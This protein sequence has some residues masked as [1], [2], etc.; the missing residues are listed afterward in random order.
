MSRAWDVYVIKKQTRL[1]EASPNY[2]SY[3][4]QWIW[5][6]VNVVNAVMDHLGLS[7]QLFVPS[8]DQ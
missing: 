3:S 7:H 5:V 1:T 8:D 4:E 6:V 2:L